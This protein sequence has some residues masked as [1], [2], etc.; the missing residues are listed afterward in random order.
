MKWV[1]KKPEFNQTRFVK[2]FAWLPTKLDEGKHGVII[3]LEW[4]EELQKTF[5]NHYWSP[6]AKFFENKR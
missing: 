4:Y 1:I 5:G 3:W 6:V 2:K